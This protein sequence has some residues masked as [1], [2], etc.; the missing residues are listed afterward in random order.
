LHICDMLKLPKTIPTSVGDFF[1]FFQIDTTYN[2]IIK[3]KN[4]I[5]VVASSSTGWRKCQI[6]D[7]SNVFCIFAKLPKTIPT[8]VGDFL[9]FYLKHIANIRN[10]LLWRY[11]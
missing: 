3:V 7:K 5:S 1:L 2:F 9:P 11:I 6:Y 4:L 10:L 8:S